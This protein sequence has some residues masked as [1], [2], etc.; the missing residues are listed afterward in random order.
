MEIC[1]HNIAMQ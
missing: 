1:N